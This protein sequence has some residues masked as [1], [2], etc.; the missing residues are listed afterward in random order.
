MKVLIIGIGS[1][2]QKHIEALR[3]LEPAIELFG[4]RST[5]QSTHKE[6]VI[7]V[8]SWKEVPSD[9]DFIII[10]N[11]TSEHYK[12]IEQAIEFKVP[13]FIEK[14]S[15]ANLEGSEKLLKAI[16]QHKITTYIAFP[17][18]FNPVVQWLKTN[19]LDKRVVE[20]SAYCGSY[21]PDWR[22]GQD[23]T[24]TYSAHKNLG[25][26]VHLDLI[27]ELDYVTWLLGLPVKADSF[28][29]KVSN[30]NIDTFDSAHYWLAYKNKNASVTLN[31]Y[32]RDAKR[33]LTIV[34]DADT[35]V[36]DLLTNEIKDQTGTI[37]FKANLSQKSMYYDQMNY[38]IECLTTGKTPMNSLRES[39]KVVEICLMNSYER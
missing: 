25:G 18:R 19:L 31:Y 32:R 9:L 12:A 17:L 33:E 27:H 21:L 11:P 7:D 22:P 1:I 2:A 23:Y 30:L 26:G 15:L 37:I 8:Y 10:S 5:K 3:L 29:S 20:L 4:L 34:M 14:P 39:L 24:T 28:F 6:G 38:F 16:E 13:L 36:A 35:W